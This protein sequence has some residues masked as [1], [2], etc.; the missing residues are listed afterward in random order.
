[1]QKN[2]IL[3]RPPKFIGDG[4][5][6]FCLDLT[7]IRMMASLLKN[8]TIVLASWGT[9]ALLEA[10]IFDRPI[11]QLRWMKAFQRKYPEQASKVIDYQRYLHLI[12]F[13]ETRCRLFSYVLEK[14]EQDIHTFINNNEAFRKNRKEA[15]LRL[16]VPPL[17]DAPI[18]VI[19]V[20]ANKLG[21]QVRPQ[22]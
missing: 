14:L 12:P 2:L 11:I 5:Y 10:A 21:I 3:D 22:E 20:I 7:E 6:G 17:S 8:A 13:D 19:N 15:V 9:T 4:E 1:M 18:R 16:A